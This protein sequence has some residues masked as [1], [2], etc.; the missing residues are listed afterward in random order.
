MKI[1]QNIIHREIAGEHILLPIGEFALQYSGVFAITEVGADI[2]E[3]LQ[4]GKN[5]QEITT[6]LMEIYDVKKE[7]LEKDIDEF[8]Q[9]LRENDLIRDSF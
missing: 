4:N 8:L 6:A 9:M 7:V 1:N 5:I 3:M 2:W